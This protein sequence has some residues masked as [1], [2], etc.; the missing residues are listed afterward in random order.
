M[1]Y[2]VDEV[3]VIGTPLVPVVRRLRSEHAFVAADGVATQG[4]SGVADVR[5][6]PLV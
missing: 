6:G 3:F 4:P 5:E 2:Y 1:R